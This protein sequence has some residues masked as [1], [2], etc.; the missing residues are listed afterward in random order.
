MA[1]FQR[2]TST[3]EEAIRPN[4]AHSDRTR[5]LTPSLDAAIAATARIPPSVSAC[6]IPSP[7]ISANAVSPTACSQIRVT[8][9]R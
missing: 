5:G 2:C 6:T 1:P 8:T 3:A 4:E 7:W 9:V